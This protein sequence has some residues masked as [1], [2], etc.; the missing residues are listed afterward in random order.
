M[1]NVHFAV[2][3]RAAVS[4]LASQGFLRIRLPFFWEMLQPM[5]HDTPANNEASV[6]IGQS[7]DFHAG[8]VGFITSVLLAHTTLGAKCTWICTT[9]RVTATFTGKPTARCRD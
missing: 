9:A 8:Y 4:N 7:G 5:V 1:P 3:R 2:T 6:A